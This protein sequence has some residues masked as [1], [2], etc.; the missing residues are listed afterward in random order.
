M[1]TVE[2]ARQKILGSARQTAKIEVETPHALGFVTTA[3]I[4]ANRTQPPLALSA[5]D[6]YA[7]RGEDLDG[8]QLSGLNIIGE[9][10]AGHPYDGEVATGECVRIYTGSVVPEGADTVVIQENVS[11]HDDILTINQNP[12]PGANVRA[13][14]TDFHRGECVMKKG[15]RLNER[16]IGLLAAANISSLSVAKRPRVGILSTGDEIVPLGITPNDG[17]ITESVAPLL[18]AM[19]SRAGGTPTLLGIAGDRVEEITAATTDAIDG[20]DILVTIGGASVGD[21]DLVRPAMEAAGLVVDFWKIAMKPGKP[22]M[23]GKFGNKPLLGLPGNPVSAYVCATL[24]LVPLIESMQGVALPGPLIETAS[25]AVPLPANGPRE[26]YMR[27]KL[28]PEP[29]GRLLAAPHAMQDSSVL[30]ALASS[31][32]LIRREANA[33]ALD[34]GSLVQIIRLQA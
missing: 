15:V 21:Y 10:P 12:S 16:D 32:C 14:G 18:G 33:S 17:Q 30:S 4:R 5:M 9:A 25:L 11:R 24:F 2:Q 26:T 8:N 23:F 27:G 34:E 6:G 20:L 7:L 22:L 31:D 29:G 1:L 3:D 19:V 28:L 13:P